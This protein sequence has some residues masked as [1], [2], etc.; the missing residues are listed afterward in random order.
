MAIKRYFADKD[1]T[2]TDAYQADLVTRG[3]G[4]NMGLADSLEVFY[5]YAQESSASAEKSRISN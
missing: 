5:I 2:I 4:S 3:T 1:N